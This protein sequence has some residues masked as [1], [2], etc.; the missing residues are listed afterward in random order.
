MRHSDRIAVSAL[1]A[2]VTA[3][4]PAAA[5]P[6]GTAADSAWR[7]R[8]RS[9][10]EAR[11]QH[12]AWGPAHAVRDYEMTLALAAAERVTVDEAAVYAAAYLHDMGAFPEFAQTGVDHADRAVALADSVLRDAGFPMEKAPLVKQIIGHHMYYHTPGSAPEAVLFRDADVLDFLGAIGAARILSLAT[13]HRWATDLPGAVETIRRN[14]RELPATL[15]S[16][17]AK[18]EGVRRVAEMRAFLDALDAEARAP[19]AL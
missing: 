14:M 11:L 8:V 16:E 9:F 6:R 15:R 12:T 17:S 19:G 3:A 18:R 2:F 7:E 13:R 5:Q 4:M 1:A 10:A